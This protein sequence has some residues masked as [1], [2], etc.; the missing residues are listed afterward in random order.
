[1]M[2]YMDRTFCARYPDGGCT[3]SPR[4]HL[5][6]EMREDAERR[7]LPVAFADL[8]GG[9]KRSAQGGGGA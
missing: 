8:C 9:V 5:T 3:C 1:M 6:P 2:C 4:R 7:G